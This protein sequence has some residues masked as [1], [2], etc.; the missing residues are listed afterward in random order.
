MDDALKTA[1]L[2]ILS[3]VI[4]KLG[5]GPARMTNYYRTPCSL[6][7]DGMYTTLQVS[8]S[9]PSEIWGL[10]R[11]YS[12]LTDEILILLILQKSGK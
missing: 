12:I 3:K 10:S 2:E 7:R 1:S 5:S 6:Y 9:K 8:P 11:F 4:I